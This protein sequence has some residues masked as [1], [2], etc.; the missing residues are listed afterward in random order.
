VPEGGEA[1]GGVAE[2]ARSG[3]RCL[4]LELGGQGGLGV[5][6]FGEAGFPAGFQGAGDEPVFRFAGAEGPFGAVGLVAGAGDGEFGGAGSALAAVGDL[7]GRG[8][9]QCELCGGRSR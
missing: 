5:G 1:G 9:G 2:F 3:E 7:A 4:V 8:D 6:E